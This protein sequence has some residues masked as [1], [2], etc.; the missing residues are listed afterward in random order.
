MAKF[1]RSGEIFQQ[2]VDGKG[3][4]LDWPNWCLLPMAGWYAIVSAHHNVMRLPLHLISDLSQLAA[5]A[6]WR[7]SQGIY[8]IDPEVLE[9]LLD[10]PLSPN[11]TSNQLFNLP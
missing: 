5:L 10:N 2:F 1:P 9:E 8:R 3:R 7:Y 4:D 6:T 11:L